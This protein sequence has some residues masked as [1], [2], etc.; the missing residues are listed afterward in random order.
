LQSTVQKDRFDSTVQS[1]NGLKIVRGHFVSWLR[2][3]RVSGGVLSNKLNGETNIRNSG[4]AAE[5]GEGGIIN[6][7]KYV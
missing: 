7:C 5:G 2:D 6:L 3:G 4:Q 1:Y